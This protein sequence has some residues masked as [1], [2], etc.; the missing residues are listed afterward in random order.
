MEFEI[1]DLV[2][3]TRIDRER[4]CFVNGDILQITHKSHASNYN[5]KVIHKIND[6]DYNGD[7]EWTLYDECEDF[8]LFE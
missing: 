5:V 2:I 6:T 4:H 3:A 7:L 1:G 8:D